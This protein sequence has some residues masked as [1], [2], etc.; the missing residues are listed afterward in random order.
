MTYKRV[1]QH[2]DYPNYLID[3]DGQVYGKLKGG[4][5]YG[6]RRYKLTN[7]EGQAKSIAGHRVTWEAWNEETIP[8]GMQVHHKNWDRCDNHIDN[9]DVVT[10][11]ENCNLKKPRT[12]TFNYTLKQ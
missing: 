5:S 7:A 11:K 3:E 1:K 6:Y 8:E 12:S 2:P 10:P 4:C 9:L